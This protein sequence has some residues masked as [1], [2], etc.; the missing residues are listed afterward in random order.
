MENVMVSSWPSRC[1]LTK[2]GSKSQRTLL[3]LT[4]SQ[5]SQSTALQPKGAVQ[6]KPSMLYVR[7]LTKPC[8]KAM[9]MSLEEQFI[10]IKP[11]TQVPH[12]Q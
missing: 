8:Q 12:Q 1:M 4:Y 9:A 3:A 2:L 6:D 7:Q 11:T 10:H 5:P